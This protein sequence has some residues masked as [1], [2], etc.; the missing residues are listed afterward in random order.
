MMYVVYFLYCKTCCGCMYVKDVIIYIFFQWLHFV[1][2]CLI[3]FMFDMCI[4][5]LLIDIKLKLYKTCIELVQLWI[6]MC[7]CPKVLFKIS[8][9]INYYQ[10]FKASMIINIQQHVYIQTFQQHKCSI[11]QIIYVISFHFCVKLCIK[12]HFS[13][14]FLFEMNSK[15][16]KPP[17]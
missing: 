7:L 16:L 12:L 1:W 6:F 15:E 11:F 17:P 3:L 5:K 14:C 4:Y 8:I 13:F 9:I 10:L 2:F